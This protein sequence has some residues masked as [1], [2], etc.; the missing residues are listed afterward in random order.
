MGLDRDDM[1][2]QAAKCAKKVRNVQPIPAHHKLKVKG[3]LK[4]RL[5]HIHVSLRMASDS[6]S[7]AG[8]PLPS[9]M[10]ELPI[11]SVSV[12]AYNMPCLLQLNSTQLNCGDRVPTYHNTALW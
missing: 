12:T 10:N 1:T 8:S 11:G 5:R 9:G 3:A 7:G 4:I 6:C 2:Q